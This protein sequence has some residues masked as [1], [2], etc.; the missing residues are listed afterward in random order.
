MAGRLPIATDDVAERF[1][2]TAPPET[3]PLGSSDGRER[4]RLEWGAASIDR[5][6][7]GPTGTRSAGALEGDR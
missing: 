3:R 5:R 2:E 4:P 6:S 7:A 1:D